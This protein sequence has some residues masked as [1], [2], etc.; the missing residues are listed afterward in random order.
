LRISANY[1]PAPEA[2]ERC[3]HQSFVVELTFWNFQMIVR[4]LCHRLLLRATES[5]IDHAALAALGHAPSV[6][7][8]ASFLWKSGSCMK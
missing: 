2:H 1:Q 4:L 5:V 8:G 6:V 7:S 3:S